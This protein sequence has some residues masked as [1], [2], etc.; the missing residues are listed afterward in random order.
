MTTGAIVGTIAIGGAKFIAAA[1]VGGFCLGIGIWCARKV[2]NRIDE[3][4]ILNNREKLEEL[5]VPF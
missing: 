3:R 2:T 1:L 5:A 4:L